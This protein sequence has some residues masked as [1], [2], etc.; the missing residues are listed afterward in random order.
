[1]FY[2]NLFFVIWL[3]VMNG[4]LREAKNLIVGYVFWYGLGLQFG[5]KLDLEA[6][7][8]GSSE[9]LK[10]GKNSKKTKAEFLK[11]NQQIKKAIYVF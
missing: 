8:M 7:E 5:R 4:H 3:L 1:M 6:T 11:V 2:K 9:Q 10:F